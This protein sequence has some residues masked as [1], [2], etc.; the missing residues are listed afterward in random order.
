L[1]VD[2]LTAPALKS[3]GFHKELKMPYPREIYE[4]NALAFENQDILVETYGASPELLNGT[5]KVPMIVEVF[6]VLK[7]HAAELEGPML[8]LIAGCS[9]ILYRENFHEKR[10]EAE[11]IHF[12]THPLAS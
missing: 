2:G 12:I 10:T 5:S 1:A 7:D 11:P 4:I 9:Y 8:E 6:R 3:R